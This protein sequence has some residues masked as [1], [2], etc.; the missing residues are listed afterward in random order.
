MKA[1]IYAAGR[2]T[3]LGP[4]FARK[5][6]ILIEFGGKS[7]LEWHALRLSEIGVK[8]I[9]VVTGHE[10]QQIAD[11]LPR[12]SQQYGV[13]LEEIENPNFCEGSVISVDVSLRSILSTQSKCVLLMDGD[14][15]YPRALIQKLL[16]SPHPTSMVVDR[17]WST[18]DDD[19]VL[20]PMHQGRPFDFRKKWQGQA[21]QTG[22][23]VGFFK[24]ARVDVPLLVQETEKRTVGEGRLES[25]D[26]IIRAM[27]LAGRFGAEDI[28]GM[29][30]T[31]VD[32]P[33]DVEYG[34]REV[35]PEILRTNIAP[36]ARQ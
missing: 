16:S 6:K 8:E 31:E 36:S 2:A 23:S 29:P 28:T 22:E 15:L 24:I 35:L 11:C 32:F 20:V 4:E 33:R 9:A 21:E 7:L 12:L 19:P 34:N 30:W 14:V 27:V 5:P 3:R 10:R 1:F 17:H 26:N 25:Y 18:E 13:S